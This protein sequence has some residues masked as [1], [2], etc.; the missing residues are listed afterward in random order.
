M[1]IA[2][3]CSAIPEQRAG[4]GVY[5]YELVRALA[6]AAGEHELAVFARPGL[7]DDLAARQA[8]V[9]VVRIPQRS[10]V[11]RF[12]WEQAM[13][14]I[15]LRRLAIDLLH[16]PHHH[17]PLATGRRRVVTFHDTTFLLMPERYPLARRLYMAGTTRVSA[18]I[19]DAIITPSETVRDDVIE[20]LGV[21]SERIITI[22]EAA[23]QQYTPIDDE[24]A[25]GRVRWRHKLPNRF[26]LSVGSLE[27][28]KN[29]TRLI[30]AY[31][32]LDVGI[33]CP[34]VVAGQPAWRYEDEFALV[35]Q[36]GLDEQVRFLGY[37][38]ADE[39]PAL[40]NAAT[41]LAFPSLYE[42]FGLP[43]LEAMACGTPVLT[44]KGSAPAE[45]AEDAA[46]LVDPFSVDDLEEA[47]H[48]LLSDE[49]LRAE[50]RA[51]GL[52]RS[53][54]FSWGRTARETLAV[55]ERFGS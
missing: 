45:V 41:L 4:A 40:Y 30:Q 15:L 11:G 3:D 12:V 10:R 50:L 22:P 37:V 14:P 17:T 54:Q 44:S 49:T 53:R 20:R 51:H 48:R 26:I 27:P 8:N 33:E 42:G 52:E 16:S 46:L 9:Q 2:V 24:E 35:K 36:L 18:R 1:R 7:F 5:T 25:L 6:D 32:R 19:A 31:A 55:Y 34:L 21:S 47:L 28:G 29:R 39:M 13:L 38:P 43:V 23:G